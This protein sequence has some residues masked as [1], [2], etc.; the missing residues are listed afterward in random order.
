MLK[1]VIA[2]A[3]AITVFSTTAAFGQISMGGAPQEDIKVSID[4][5]G[6]AHVVHE[7]QGNATGAVHVET[8]AGS[9]ANF[10]VTD[11]ADNPVQYS[12]IGQSPM[13]ILLLPTQRNV[14]L[15]TYDIPN[16]VS[17]DSGVWNWH[18]YA[19][20]D[21][22]FTD[23]YFPKGVDMV[24]SNDRPV[25]LGEKGLRQIGNG[26]DLAYIINEPETIQTVQ[27]QNQT[28]NVGI[29]TLANVGPLVFDQSAKAYA[30]DI[31]K[32]D[33]Y[34]TIIMPK[35]LLWGPYQGTINTNATLT[36]LFN[37]NGTHAWI[38]LK[39]IHNG[40][41]QI[42]GTTAIPEFPMFVPL[43]IAISAVV[44]LRFTNRLNFH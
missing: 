20:S 5:N 30:F 18:Y 29:R 21:A 25:Y 8:I 1:L 32:P 31:D 26:M 23:F 33:S 44:A 34:V 42:T 24:W 16:A 6:T 7:V 11:Q 40:T 38:G 19:P 4:D 39:P 41:L 28:F 17:Y 36:N 12:T 9:I 15:V 43:A 22:I 27:W 13:S 2:F 37:D 35:A 3:I 14:T 10:S